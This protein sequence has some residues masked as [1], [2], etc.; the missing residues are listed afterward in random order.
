M[1][2]AEVKKI[3]RGR[4][5][6]KRNFSKVIRASVTK[7]QCKDTGMA[8]VL[9]SL[10]LILFYRNDYV[11]YGAIIIQV[12]NMVW[13]QLFR[14]VAVIWFGLS[15][16]LGMITSRIIL[17]VIFIAVVTPVGL[18]RRMLGADS[19]RLKLFKRDRESVME[20]RNHKYIADDIA[21]PY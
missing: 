11:L 15:H 7:E 16:V 13:P 21:K 2:T 17:S 9:L 3:G 4:S 8:M 18:I 20:E 19:L 12:V 6:M 10:L 5:F 1:G 14:P